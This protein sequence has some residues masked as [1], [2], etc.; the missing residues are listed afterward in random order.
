MIKNLTNLKDLNTAIQEAEENL[1]ALIKGKERLEKASATPDHEFCRIP[2]GEVEIDNTVVEVEPYELSKYPTTNAQFKAFVEAED[3]YKN[4]KW[5]EGMPEESHKDGPV[6]PRWEEDD[7]PRET[8]NWHEATAYCR[9]LSARLGYEVFLPHEAEWQQAAT[10]GNPD[11]IY[12]WGE[13]PDS[14]KCNIYE[15]NIGRTTPVTA[16]PQGATEQGVQD[17][18][19]NVWEWCSNLYHKP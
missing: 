13:E 17:M 19:G 10:S 7:C 9:W 14:G 15:S 18:A 3:G 1:V 12:P 6:D 4:P 11:N 16:H 8:V 2:G 5:W